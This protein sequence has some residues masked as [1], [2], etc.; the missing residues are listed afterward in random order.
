[1]KYKSMN[2]CSDYGETGS[3]VA[4]ASVWDTVTFG[5]YPQS[6]LEKKKPIEWVVLKKEVGKALLLSKYVLFAHEYIDFY[7]YIG[8][9]TEEFTKRHGYDCYNSDWKSHLWSLST[10][11]HKL[12]SEF[13]TTAFNTTEQDC[14]GLEEQT[15]KHL[16][17]SLLDREVCSE[18]TE[19]K[20]FVL[21]ADDVDL[22]FES[23]H[24]NLLTAKP[25]PYAI[26]SGVYVRNGNSPWWLRSAYETVNHSSQLW[27][28][29]VEED[30]NRT[31]YSSNAPQKEVM[32]FGVRPAIWVKNNKKK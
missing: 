14:I 11:R 2:V 23:P 20:I 3:R 7:N 18:K 25:T 4:S 12:N 13:I 17:R 1:M 19:E 15:T 30:G 29:C 5:N 22:I 31:G 16:L 10:L 32:R 21:D 9:N 26:K 28:S 8:R 27:I 24:K 6:D